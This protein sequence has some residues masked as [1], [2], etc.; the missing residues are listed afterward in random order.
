MK[1][2]ILLVLTIVS[3]SV[4]AS[5]PDKKQKKEQKPTESSAVVVKPQ[6][7]A[8]S[9]SYAA[10]QTAT[11]GLTEYVQ[12][13]YGVD[14]TYMADFIEGY[15]EAM[16]SLNDP[17]YKA[18]N[19]GI[20]IA[21]MV[22]ERILPQTQSQFENTEHAIEASQFN[23]GFL[24]AV[25]GDTTTMTVDVAKNMFRTTLEADKEKQNAAYR[26]ENEAW[27]AAN[28]TKEGVVTTPSG[29][30]Y[31]I[32]T[33]G[34]GEVPT[35]DDKVTVK[36]EGRLIDGTEFDS[37]YKRKPQTSTFGVSQ[38]VKGW[39]EALTMMPVGSKW[40]LYLPQ[41]LAYG[42]RQAGKIKPYSTLIFT[43]ELVSVEHK[44]NTAQGKK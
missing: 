12:R 1:K 26:Q 33:A 29:L 10:G 4:M 44:E 37:S 32:I 24:D 28:K 13:E 7:F 5:T 23:N 27:L 15:N 40:E 6:T 19:A 38:V 34:Q 39:T 43:V 14:T 22:K 9:L 17:K 30:Q 18:R 42:S 2:I 35:K 21:R 11:I 41:E 3:V 8:D 31:K 20:Q 25:K 16:G 36:Y